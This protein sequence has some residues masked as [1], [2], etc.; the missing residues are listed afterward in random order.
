MKKQTLV[1]LGML[2]LAG[3]AQTASASSSAQA[4]IDWDNISFKLVDYSG[5]LNA[6]TLN[7]SSKN[8][9]V[10]TSATTVDP[11]DSG[12]ANQT[13]NNFTTALSSETDTLFAQSSATRNSTGLS[14]SASSQMGAS[15]AGV[16]FGIN[17]ASASASNSGNFQLG[18]NGLLLISMDWGLSSTGPTGD[19][20]FG[21]IGEW[22]SSSISISGSYS[23]QFTSGNAS[24][25]YTTTP[26][27]SFGGPESQSSTFV[28]AIFNPGL[29]IISGS[30]SALVSASTN[31]SAF[32]ASLPASPVPLPTSAWLFGSALFGF[33]AQRKRR[34]SSAI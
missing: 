10:S 9:T 16:N 33:L 34:F 12:S 21:G 20:Y 23:G 29:G 19:L 26:Y 6:P 22:A 15:E 30:I 24:A 17:A 27:W 25:S 3:S 28:M 13:R 8:G 11:N 14:A 5:G 31:S 1:F 2:A 7:W 32:V 4:F 18:G